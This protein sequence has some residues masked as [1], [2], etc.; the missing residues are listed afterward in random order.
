MMSGRSRV[1][2]K[3]TDGVKH[4]NEFEVVEFRR[5]TIRGNQELDAGFTPLTEP[6]SES[7]STMGFLGSTPE[8]VI[9][10]STRRSR[11]PWFGE[12]K[13]ESFNKTPVHPADPGKCHVM[14]NIV[15]PV[16]LSSKGTEYNRT[17]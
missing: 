2:N 9:L 10:G 5:Y 4:M 12:Q 14:S 13:N 15:F 8:L 1:G 6:S 16:R 7:L 11:L 17:L 3:A